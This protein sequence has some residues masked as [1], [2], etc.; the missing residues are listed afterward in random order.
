MIIDRYLLREIITPFA[1]ISIALLTV[2]LA[3]SITAVL[4]NAGSDLLQPAEIAQLSFL[5]AIIALEVLLP[6]GL[7]LGV[8]ADTVHGKRDAVGG[9]HETGSARC[10]AAVSTRPTRIPA[11]CRL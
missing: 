10:A 11:R 5:K 3:Y 2:F 6:M 8:M 7:Y 1:G 9:R 4:A